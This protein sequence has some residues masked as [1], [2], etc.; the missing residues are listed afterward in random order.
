MRLQSGGGAARVPPVGALVHDR[1]KH[2]SPTGLAEAVRRDDDLG[3]V[4][5]LDAIA[6]LACDHR[7]KIGDGV[8]VALRETLHAPGLLAIAGETQDARLLA[9]PK[10]PDMTLLKR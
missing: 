9:G 4:A 10:Q 1:Q 8:A 2:C 5:Q 6:G 3:A 7:A